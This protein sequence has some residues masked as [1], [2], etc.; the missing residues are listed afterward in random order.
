M[1][2]KMN[3][4][5][6]RKTVL[7]VYYYKS[8]YITVVLNVKEKFFLVEM[9]CSF[10]IHSV[11]SCFLNATTFKLKENNCEDSLEITNIVRPNIF[12]KF[13]RKL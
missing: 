10:S 4:I 6:L 11:S 3:K 1:K 12:N 5:C 7:K 8:D 9:V 13:F 2:S